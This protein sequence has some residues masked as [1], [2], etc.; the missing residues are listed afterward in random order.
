MLPDDTPLYACGFARHVELEFWGKQVGKSEL[1]N[2]TGVSV[3]RVHQQEIHLCMGVALT[4]KRNHYI[5]L[6]RLFMPDDLAANG[7]A[8]SIDAL[9]NDRGYHG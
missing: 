3:D 2:D 7:A 9:S 4:L 6:L 5:Y 8:G 1:A